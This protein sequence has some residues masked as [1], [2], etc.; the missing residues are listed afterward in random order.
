MKSTLNI[1]LK[2]IFWLTIL[3]V[4]VTFY[5][6]TFGQS[7]TYEIADGKL[8]QQ[9]YDIIMQGLPI[10]VLLTLTGTIKRTY[11]KSKNIAIIVV[12]IIGS[13]ISFF[14]M[15]SLLFSVGFLTITND[16]LL[17]RDK[18]RPTTIIMSQTIGQ[19]ALGED[20]H[21]TVKLEPFLKFWNK[22]TI[23]DTTTID[24]SEWIFVSKK[25]DLRNGK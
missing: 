1:I 25:I 5:A 14:I 9:F 8:K 4:V 22:T 2:T 7:S 6:L 13:I 11:D 23:I 17:Y 12:T 21:R 24:K 20:G 18:T 16:T 3:F 19:G 15:V 10:A